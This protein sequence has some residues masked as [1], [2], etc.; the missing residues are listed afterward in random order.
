MSLDPPGL[1]QVYPDAAAD[2]TGPPS[3]HPALRDL[4]RAEDDGFRGVLSSCIQ[5]P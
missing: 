5:V 1:A 4:L 2:E 3:A